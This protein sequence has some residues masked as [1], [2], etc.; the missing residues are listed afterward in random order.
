MISRA[1]DIAVSVS[2]LSR[3]SFEPCLPG[4]RQGVGL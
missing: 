3:P 2:T 4:G 1:V